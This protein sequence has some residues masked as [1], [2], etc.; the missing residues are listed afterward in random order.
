MVQAKQANT[1][2]RYRFTNDL[3]HC[4]DDEG[5]QYYTAPFK[6][7]DPQ[8]VRRY[9]AD[10]HQV[11]KLFPGERFILI[12]TDNKALA[13]FQ[14]SSIN[15]E[16]SRAYA[17]NRCRVI[18]KRGKLIRCKDTNSCARC[19]FGRTEWDREPITI[20]WNHEHE[21][22]GFDPEDENVDVENQALTDVMLEELKAWLDARDHRI[23]QALEMKIRGNR[24]VREIADAL[25]VSPSLVYHL[26]EQAEEI[27]KRYKN[28]E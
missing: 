14:W 9:Q 23:M 4:T 16:H 28:A 3:H 6:L 18:G 19:P 2:K 1:T 15:T 22:N 27:G 24:S 13:D 20:S 11:K 17:Q 7:E 21:E 8:D 26:F 5:N 25:G 10:W 12:P